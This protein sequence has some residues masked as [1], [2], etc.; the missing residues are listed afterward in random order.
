MHL[1]PK[2][3]FRYCLWMHMYMYVSLTKYPKQTDT[4]VLSCTCSYDLQI[5]KQKGIYK[6][7]VIEERKIPNTTT[8]LI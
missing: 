5:H 4:D 6:N 2:Y 1:L 8:L 3:C 7:M